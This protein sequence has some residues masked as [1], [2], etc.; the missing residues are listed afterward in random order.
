MTVLS[1]FLNRLK[2]RNFKKNINTIEIG[3]GHGTS[4][5]ITL[6]AYDKNC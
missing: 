1:N 6:P 3:Q 2:W 5:I 4:I